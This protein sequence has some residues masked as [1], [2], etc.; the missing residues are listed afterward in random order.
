VRWPDGKQQKESLDVVKALDAAFPDTA[1]LWPPA[2]TDAAAVGAAVSAFRATFPRNARPSSR[3]AF[4][5]EWDGDPLPRSAFESTLDATE[6]LLEAAG[7][8]FFAGASFSAADV[9]WAPFL[10]RYAAQLPC[11][12]KGLVP[13]DPSRWPC[14]AA[15]Y[16][17]ME[18]RV[19]A[20]ACRVRGD[21]A[22]WRKVLSMAGFGNAGLPQRMLTDAEE[23][24]A[25]FGPPPTD[26]ATWAAYAKAR[27]MHSICTANAR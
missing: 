24:D 2:G 3:A 15:W 26:A 13:R 19:P 16:D 10:E 12:H 7:G 14:L 20:Y 4:L 8:P 18:A 27:Y 9:A 17:A 11:L 22:S 21:A 5:F 25:A 6:A 23:T 1:P